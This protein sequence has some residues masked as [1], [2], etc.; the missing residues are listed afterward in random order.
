MQRLMRVFIT[1]PPASFL[2]LPLTHPPTCKKGN[3]S[4]T[5]QFDAWSTAMSHRFLQQQA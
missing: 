1:P 2:F 3:G 4:L 5:K